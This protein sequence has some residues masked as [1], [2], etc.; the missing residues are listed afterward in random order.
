MRIEWS[1]VNQRPKLVLE[2]GEV[3][4]GVV[5]LAL[6][7]TTVH[8]LHMLSQNVTQGGESTTLVPYERPHPPHGEYH[9]YE[10]HV[11][12]QVTAVP[13][14]ALARENFR[15][16]NLPYATEPLLSVSCQSNGAVLLCSW[17]QP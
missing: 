14:Q 7:D 10:V 2:R 11:L 8:R 3:L 9:T 5:T 15:L 13:P 6:V 4:H 12:Q 17:D 1:R 16:A